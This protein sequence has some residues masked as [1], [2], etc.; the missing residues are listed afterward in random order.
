MIIQDYEPRHTE[1]KQW[2]FAGEHLEVD[3]RTITPNA[4]NIKKV[5]ERIEK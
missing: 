2:A 3:I 5:L 4:E 1:R